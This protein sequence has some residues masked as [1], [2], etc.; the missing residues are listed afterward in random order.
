MSV[1][2][3]LG[4]FLGER[5][6]LACGR[7]GLLLEFIGSEILRCTGFGIGEEGDPLST[8]LAFG[9]SRAKRAGIEPSPRRFAIA[10]SSD[11]ET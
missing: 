4:G 7:S 6:V 1:D 9:T 5:D 10:S 11:S 2:E 8:S 3:A